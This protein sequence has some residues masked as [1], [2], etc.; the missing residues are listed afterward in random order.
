VLLY[1]FGEDFVL[2]LQMGHAVSDLSVLAVRVDLAAF[3]VDGEIGLPTLEEG[4]LPVVEKGNADAVLFAEIGNRDF[5]EKVLPEYGDLLLRRELATLPSHGCSSA[6]VCP[7][8]LAK[9]SSSFDWCN[10]AQAQYKI[11]QL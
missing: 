2:A 3:V 6:R 1:E 5:V 7:L 8:A 4:L 11:D 10:T 9:A